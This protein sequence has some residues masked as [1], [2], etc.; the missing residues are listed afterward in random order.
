MFRDFNRKPLYGISL[1]S[2]EEKIKYAEQGGWRLHGN[3]IQQYNGHYGCMV[4]KEQK[5]RA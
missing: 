3:I 2:L 5:Q 1:H 4:I